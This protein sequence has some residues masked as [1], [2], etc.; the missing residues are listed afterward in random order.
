MEWNGEGWQ[1]MAECYVILHKIAQNS[2]N[3][4]CNFSDVGYCHNNNLSHVV[5]KSVFGVSDQV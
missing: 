4:L 1:D 5:R 3:L 2:G